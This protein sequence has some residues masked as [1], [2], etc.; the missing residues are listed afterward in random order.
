MCTEQ[1]KCPEIQGFQDCYALFKCK[2]FC[3][4]AAKTLHLST[5]YKDTRWKKHSV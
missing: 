3:G 1:R 2:E 5:E 4:F